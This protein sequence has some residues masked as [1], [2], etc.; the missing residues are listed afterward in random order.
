MSNI[1]LL[2]IYDDNQK[3]LSDI[4]TISTKA[5]V[6]KH[7]IDYVRINVSDIFISESSDLKV[8]RDLHPAYAKIWILFFLNLYDSQYDYIWVLDIDTFFVNYE[9][10]IKD[11]IDEH[12]CDYDEDGVDAICSVNGVNGGK[13]LN[14]GSI[15]YRLYNIGTLFYL[16]ENYR[17]SRNQTIMNQPFW[18]QDFLND[19]HS[20]FNEKFKIKP[21]EMNVLNS[22]WFSYEHNQLLFHFMARSYEEKIK[23]ATKRIIEK[24]N[25]L[26]I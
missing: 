3:S 4:T 2:Q 18:E 17:Q 5:Y 1:L 12:L 6:K 13:L 7:N 11:I 19:V 8:F 14:T 9:I 23:I 16:F 15:V 26:G 22:Y 21:L 24:Q 20:F 25:P 10:N